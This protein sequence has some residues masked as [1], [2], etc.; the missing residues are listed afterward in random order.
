MYFISKE[1]NF[2]FVGYLKRTPTNT[3][4]PSYQTTRRTGSNGAQYTYMETNNDSKLQTKLSKNQVK[5]L[6]GRRPNDQ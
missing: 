1:T 5:T 2:S 3:F 4:S 6:D